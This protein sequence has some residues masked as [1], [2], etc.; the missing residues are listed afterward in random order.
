MIDIQIITVG[1]KHDPDFAEKIRSYEKRLRGH[2]KLSWQIIP[3]SD[4]LGESAK[5]LEKINRDDYVILLDERGILV[6]NSQLVQ[7]FELLA[8]QAKRLVIII[9]GSYGIDQSVVGR[10]NQVVAL[11]G[12]VLPHQLVRLI[13]VEQIYRTMTIINN[14]NYHH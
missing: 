14:Q 8:Q 5:I 13:V 6:S 7:A 2:V 12:L 11:S 4:K 3:S 1:K 9:G 10:A